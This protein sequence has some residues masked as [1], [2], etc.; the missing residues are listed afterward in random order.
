MSEPNDLLEEIA[1]LINHGLN[2]GEVGLKPHGKVRC[3][4]CGD[5]V[6]SKHRHDFQPC[7]CGAIFV[8]GGTDY[9]RLGGNPED[10]EVLQTA[11]LRSDKDESR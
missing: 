2:K 4:K 10:M 5:V 1:H 7:K 6:E 3:K 11:R 8:D 9:T